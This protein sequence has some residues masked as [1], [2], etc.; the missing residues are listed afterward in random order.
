MLNLS[1]LSMLSSLGLGLL[2]K[3]NFRV[4][5]VSSDEIPPG[6]EGERGVPP[7]QGLLFRRGRSALSSRTSSLQV[8]TVLV[9]EAS[10]RAELRAKLTLAG[11]RLFNATVSQKVR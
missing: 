5:Q 3:L 9:F 11:A 7:A 10:L 1:E 4:A 2:R 6:E 8:F